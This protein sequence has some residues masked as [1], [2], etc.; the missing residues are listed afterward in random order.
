M[1]NDIQNYVT[2]YRHMLLF[3]FLQYLQRS[4]ASITLSH[5]SLNDSTASRTAGLHFA[6]RQTWNVIRWSPPGLNLRP[7]NHKTGGTS[8]PHSLSSVSPLSQFRRMGPSSGGA[9]NWPL[10]DRWGGGGGLGRHRLSRGL[11]HAAAP[12]TGAL[13]PDKSTQSKTWLNP[14]SLRLLVQISSETT[15][16]PILLL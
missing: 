12:P 10:Y 9:Q 5:G 13:T 6:H 11:L 1:S 7:G 3:T 8:S 4:Q 15:L 2:T 14:Q 16:S